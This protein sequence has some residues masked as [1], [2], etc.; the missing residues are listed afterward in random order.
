MKSRHP[1]VLDLNNLFQPAIKDGIK[2]IADLEKTFQG[3]HQGVRALKRTGQLPFAK[4]PSD[5]VMFQQ[6]VDA[7]KKFEHVENVVVFGIGGSALGTSSLY[8]T[9]TGSYGNLLR[10]KNQGGLARLLVVDHIDPKTIADLFDLI[11]AQ[12]NLFVFISKSGNTSE[13]LGHYL[14]V[15][16]LV[17]QLNG[18]NCFVITDYENGY[19]R[20]RAQEEN[21]G[22]LSVPTGVGGRFS[23]FSPVGLFP[24]A[25]CGVD[26]EALLDGAA[27]GELQCQQDVMA[28][29]PAALLALSMHAWLKKRNFSQVVMM[30]YSDRLR[31]FSDWFAQLWAESLGKKVTLD[32]KKEF[33]GSS[34]HKSVGVTDQHSQL[35]LY[36]EGPRDKVIV[37][38]QVEETEAQGQLL[39]RELG[40]ERI[41]FLSGQ[42]L[43]E[44]M[45]MEMVA[46]E[47][48][49]READRPSAL[50]KLSLI[51]EFQ[52]GQLY[53]VFMNVIP[54]MGAL[55][56]INPFDQPAVERI[57]KFTF[58]LMGRK[59]FEDFELKIKEREKRKDLIF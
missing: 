11:E 5:Q 55:L 28:Q 29:N 22:S 39:D 48:T 31:L 25:V 10:S 4:L 37:F 19:F 3:V 59:G 51:N 49:L 47:E 54:Y 52:L 6:V 56:N 27:H 58:G 2:K 15:K 13:I 16:K 53:Q 24:L 1:L 34:P 30:P 21:Y 33:V 20:K 43:H 45:T 46:T 38:V 50:I 40:D 32:G 26:I 42:T 41:D 14:Y 23:V 17:P 18:D 12:K 57:K 35:Q 36:L 9:I 7:A 44:L 8:Q